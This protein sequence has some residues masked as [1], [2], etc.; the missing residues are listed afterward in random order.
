M[1][2]QK[3]KGNLAIGVLDTIFFLPAAGIESVL[4]LGFTVVIRLPLMRLPF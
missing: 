3:G 1:F 2:I 4:C